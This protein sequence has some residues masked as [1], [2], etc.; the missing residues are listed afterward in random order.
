M[1]RFSAVNRPGETMLTNIQQYAVLK[2]LDEE[3]H[4]AESPLQRMEGTLHLPVALIVIPLFALANAAIP[5]DLGH[6]TTTLLQPVALGIVLGLVMGK[7]LGITLFS[8]LAVKAGIAVLPEGVA[9][10]HVA[11]VGLL[12]GIGFTMSIFIAELSFSSNYEML[13]TAKTAIIIASLLSG[14]LGYFWLR[15]FSAR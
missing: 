12:G 8:W 2:G 6:F 3:L 4:L 5:L 9:M 10:R 1:G 14:V 15:I 11:G 7:F 13:V